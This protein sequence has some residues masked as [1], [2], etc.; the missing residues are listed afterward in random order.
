MKHGV[1]MRGIQSALEP[2]GAHARRIGELWDVFLIVSVVVYVLVLIALAVALLRRRATESAGANRTAAVVVSIATAISFVTLFALLVVSVLTSRANAEARN[3]ASRPR[4]TLTGHQ[5]WWQVEYED[6]DPSRRIVSANE[7]TLPAGVPV[8]VRLK[9]SDVI[10]SFWVPNLDGKQDLIPGRENSIVISANRPGVWRGQCAEFCGQQHAQMAFLVH[11]L[12][13]ADY[14]RWAER[15]RQPST[16][17][18]TAKQREGLDV[19]LRSP[20]PLCHTIRGTDASGNGGPD[21]THVASRRSLAAGALQNRRRELAT[22]IV[23]PQHV[24]PASNM[25]PM[26]LARGELDPLLDYL[27]SLQ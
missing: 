15:E 9:S 12:A 24:K 21:L 22:W 25:P 11:A 16:I 14:V 18:S 3:V 26:V 1:L 20:C 6:V 4:I 2:A 7:L 27:E 10:H 5:W 13:P 17:P 19:F 8:E 23:D